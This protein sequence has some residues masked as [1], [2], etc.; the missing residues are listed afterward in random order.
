M[1]NKQNLAIWK[2]LNEIELERVAYLINTDELIFETL[3]ESIED[4]SGRLTKSVHMGVLEE[5]KI[6]QSIN[7]PIEFL[8]SQFVEDEMT[9][10]R[11]Q[12]KCPTCKHAITITSADFVKGIAMTSCGDCGRNV[13]AIE[14]FY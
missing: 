14:E 10:F 9:L 4:E 6:L 2:E 1:T 12:Y 11:H 5:I 8:R 7:S 3:S 13:F